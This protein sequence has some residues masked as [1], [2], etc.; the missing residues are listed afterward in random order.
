VNW[1]FCTDAMS[2]SYKIGSSN[3]GLHSSI[4]VS[5]YLTNWRRNMRL[6][7][8]VSF[9]LL[10]RYAILHGI[11][12]STTARWNY[13]YLTWWFGTERKELGNVSAGYCKRTIE[14]SCWSCRNCKGMLYR[15]G[16]LWNSERSYP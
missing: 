13:Y 5:R 2:S 7:S 9:K 1:M 10:P 14:E 15:S 16:T 3:P 8:L 12:H 11:T 6:L 4:I